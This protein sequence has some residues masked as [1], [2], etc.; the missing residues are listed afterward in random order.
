[1]IT[2]SQIHVWEADRPDRPWPIPSR[3]TSKEPLGDGFFA[4]QAIAAMDAVGVD[5]AVLVPPT[6]I[7]D[8]NLTVTEAA[9]AYPTRFGIVGRIDATAPDVLDQLAGWL[10]L[11]YMHGVRITTFVTPFKEWFHEDGDV[12]WF[13]SACERL[14]I[15]I[16]L[17]VRGATRVL[18]VAER[19]PGLRLIIDH[20]ACNLDETGAVAFG[21]LDDLLALSRHPNVYVKISSAPCFSV[22]AYPFRDIE[23]FLRRLYDAFGPRRLIWG[24]DLTRLRGSYA[25]CLRHIQDG[26]PFLTADDKERIL[27]RNLT[28]V[29]DWPDA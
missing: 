3:V 21:P 5:R 2:D 10:D 4:D 20:M 13:W 6:Y 17:L 23:P 22:E 18:P 29:L 12:D 19:F 9:E 26:L 25:D 11:P 1:M 7:G 14:G 16:M 8:N 24:S 27:H 15:P 28:E